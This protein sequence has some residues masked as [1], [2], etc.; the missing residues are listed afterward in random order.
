M[1][2]AMFHYLKLIGLFDFQS[3]IYY[4]YFSKKLVIVE[5]HV[6]LLPDYSLNE[7]ELS[8]FKL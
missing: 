3:I 8:L 2:L 1:N 6:H 4:V 7:F 5:F